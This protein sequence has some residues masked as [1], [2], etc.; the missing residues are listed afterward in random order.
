MTW[1]TIAVVIVIGTILTFAT[2]PP[3]ALVGWV[4]SKF[5]LHPK[6]DSKDIT[7]T[8]NGTRLEEEEKIRF[9]DYFNEAQFLESNH[10]FPGNEKLFLHPETNV[11]P[12]VINVK[13]RKKEMNFFI[14]S[15]DD[16][17]D[18]VKQWKKKVASY[19]LRSEYLQKFTISNSIK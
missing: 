12:F 3:S 1:T 15:Y 2:C 11:I 13:S 5:A 16:H 7:V 10:I 18:V 19:S 6:L 17:V 4:L 9:N 8:F 14:Y